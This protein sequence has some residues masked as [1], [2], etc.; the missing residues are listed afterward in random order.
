MFK[1]RFLNHKNNQSKPK[2]QP[3]TKNKP[4][5]NPLKNHTHKKNPQQPNKNREINSK[6]F[7]HLLANSK[8]SVSTRQKLV[9]QEFFRHHR[10]TLKAPISRINV[11]PL[12]AANKSHE[13]KRSFRINR[14]RRQHNRR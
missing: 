2:P 10:K 12:E 11:I 6:Q 7:L 4:T 13:R 1:K 14:R 5:E 9:N 8:G 3:N